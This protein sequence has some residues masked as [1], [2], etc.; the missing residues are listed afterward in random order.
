MAGFIQRL[1]FRC[2]MPHKLAEAKHPSTIDEKLSSEVG[3]YVWMQEFC[4]DFP[5]LHLYS[6]GFSDFPAYSKQQPK[7]TELLLF[8]P[9]FYTFFDSSLYQD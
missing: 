2:P 9:T 5:I 1:L 6:F 7:Q 8:I 4:P 3:A